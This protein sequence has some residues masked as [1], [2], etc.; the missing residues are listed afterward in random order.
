M[1]KSIFNLEVVQELLIKLGKGQLRESEK[2]ELEKYLKNSFYYNNNLELRE[3]SELECMLVQSADALFNLKKSEIFNDV[4][5]VNT[6]LDSYVYE[7]DDQKWTVN[8]SEMVCG[9][10][11]ELS[12]L[13]TFDIK[14]IKRII[15]TIA[16]SKINLIKNNIQQVIDVAKNS[17]IDFEK[18]KVVEFGNTNKESCFNIKSN[19]SSMKI[20]LK[21]A[22][23]LH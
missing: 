16:D 19:I 20:S 23:A 4:E 15:G 2:I 1:N 7:F 22:I 17:K 3:L 12:D 9:V 21:L 10:M 8:A 6:E 11:Y 13:K 14:V 5:Y 18:I